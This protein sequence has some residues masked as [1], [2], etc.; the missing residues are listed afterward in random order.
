MD[1]K[2]IPKYLG[3]QNDNIQSDLKDIDSLSSNNKAKSMNNSLKNS[4]AN[5]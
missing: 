5:K 2:V 4:K 3:G 1:I